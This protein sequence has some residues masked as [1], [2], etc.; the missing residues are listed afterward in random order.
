VTFLRRGEAGGAD[1]P[2]EAGAADG[3]EPVAAAE[4]AP[5]GDTSAGDCAA[6][7]AAV[8]RLDAAVPAGAVAAEAEETSGEEGKGEATGGGGEG[9]EGMDPCAQTA[10][11]DTERAA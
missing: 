3:K 1:A 11:V 2:P 9:G 7:V 6:L 8:A 4:V 5:V 10:A